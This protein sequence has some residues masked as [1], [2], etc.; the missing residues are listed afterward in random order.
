MMFKGLLG[1]IGQLVFVEAEQFFGSSADG[2][3][4]EDMKVEVAGLRAYD[5]TY[6]TGQT[7]YG[8]PTHS[9]NLI[10][11]QNAV[12]LAFGKQPDYKFEKSQDFGIKSESA[13]EFWMNTQKVNLTAENTEDYAMAKVASMDYSVIPFDVKF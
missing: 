5:G 11:G 3:D 13:I 6:W 4:L 2:T 9:R 7:G 10:L 1:Q 12:Q 8:T